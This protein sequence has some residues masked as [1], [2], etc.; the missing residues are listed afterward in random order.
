MAS[1]RT[2]RAVAA[3]SAV[4]LA[5][6]AAAWAA[7]SG[8]YASA[9]TAALAGAW[10]AAVLVEDARGVRV[11]V[12]RQAPP[13]APLETPLLRALLNEAPAPLLLL[14]PGGAVRAVNRAAQGLFETDDRLVRPPPQL[15]RAL[16]EDAAGGRRRLTLAGAAGPGRLYALSLADVGAPGAAL[17]L[18]VQAEVHAAEADSLRRVLQVMSNELMNALTPVTSLAETAAELLAAERSEAA[19]SA[20]DA[21]AAIGRRAG[22]LTGSWT[23]TAPP[24]ACPSRGPA[25]PT[26]RSSPKTPSGS[27][28]PGPTPWACASRCT[29]RRRPWSASPI[30]SWSRRRWRTS[31]RTRWR[32]PSELPARRCR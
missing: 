10:L 26:W 13:A 18:G 2:V 1:E 4:L 32:L 28:A 29:G 3:Q 8:L 19:V 16:R 31:S 12:G 25:R 15:L 20:R 24:R 27:P 30:R 6:G 5:G 14:E 9:L 21:L 23:A 22:G 17:R 7:G 11:R